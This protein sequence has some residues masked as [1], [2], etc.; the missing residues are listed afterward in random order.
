WF[1]AGGEAFSFSYQNSQEINRHREPGSTPPVSQA[2]SRETAEG[3][4]PYSVLMFLRF[5]PRAK[6]VWLPAVRLPPGCL[7]ENAACLPNFTPSSSASGP[8]RIAGLAPVAYLNL[9]RNCVIAPLAVPVSTLNAAS[10]PREETE[11]LPPNVESWIVML[12]IPSRSRSVV[13]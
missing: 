8:S 12:S 9:P 10:S 13:P 3:T 11:K 5:G 2:L 7:A 1:L 6:L 4:I